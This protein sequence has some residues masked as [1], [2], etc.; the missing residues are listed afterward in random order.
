MEAWRRSSIALAPSVWSEPFG[1]VVIEAMAM[2]RPVIASRIGGLIDIVKDGESGFLVPAGNSA[3]LAQ[4]MKRL[5]D[6]KS[7]RERLGQAARQR[8]QDFRASVVIPR[9][10]AVYQKLTKMAVGR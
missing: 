10:E 8:S 6:D 2:G 5:L 4:A 9:I 1:I 7:L 3:A